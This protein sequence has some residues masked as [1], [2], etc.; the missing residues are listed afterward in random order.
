MSQTFTGPEGGQ[1]PRKAGYHHAGRRKD[2]EVRR[3][4]GAVCRGQPGRKPGQAQVRAAG[5][6][7]ALG[8]HHPRLHHHLGNMGMAR[9]DD[10]EQ[11]E[12]QPQ[13]VLPHRQHHRGGDRPA[14][15]AVPQQD[16]RELGCSPSG[17]QHV[18]RCPSQAAGRPDHR[19]G[20]RSADPRR[21]RDH[22]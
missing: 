20:V 17:G 10:P 16:R 22:R 15:R 2:L 14:G 3:R 5:E 9:G 7:A 18:P 1:R 12:R 4:L 11:A 13:Q 21:A 8:A 6:A 19:R